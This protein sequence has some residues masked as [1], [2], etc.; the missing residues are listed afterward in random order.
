MSDI[1]FNVA[2]GTINK[3]IADGATFRMLL[4]KGVASDAILRD[5]GTIADLLAE[6][7]TVEAD[8][9]NYARQTLGGLVGDTDNAADRIT[10]SSNSIVFANAGGAL[11]NTVLKAVIFDFITNDA[12]SIPLTAHDVN[13]TTNGNSITLTQPAGRFYSSVETAA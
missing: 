9:T 4:L 6:P 1:I 12:G 10:A 2:L 8:F 3:R 5:I 13:F 7:S 11:N